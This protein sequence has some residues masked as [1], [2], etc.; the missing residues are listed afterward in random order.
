LLT[1]LAHRLTRLSRELLFVPRPGDI[2]IVSYPRSGTTW[3]QM[4]LYQLT[5]DGSMGFDH[6]TEFIERALSLG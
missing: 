6:I 2:Y 4:I 3:L 5:S 1:K